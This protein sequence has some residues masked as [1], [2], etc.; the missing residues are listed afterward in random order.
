LIVA[1]GAL[2][3]G[4]RSQYTISMQ[5]PDGIALLRSHRGLIG[6]IARHLGIS[7]GAV[8]KWKQVPAERLPGVEAASGIPRFLLR[9]DICDPPPLPAGPPKRKR[10]KPAPKPRPKPGG[11]PEAGPAQ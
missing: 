7:R 6:R 3:V 8:A 1:P 9:P 10:P 2:A 11:Q 4:S 5:P